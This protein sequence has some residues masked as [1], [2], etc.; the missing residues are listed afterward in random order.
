[1]KRSLEIRLHHGSLRTAAIDTPR[2][3]I[4]YIRVEME[5][6]WGARNAS[7]PRRA[8]APLSRAGLSSWLTTDHWPLIWEEPGD[9]P[10]GIS[11]STPETRSGADTDPTCTGLRC[12]Y[13]DRSSP[14]RSPSCRTR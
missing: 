13:R 2:E 14:H 11:N 4:A 3:S 7:I 9:C 5:G 8:K 12:S 1:M 6:Y 10:Q